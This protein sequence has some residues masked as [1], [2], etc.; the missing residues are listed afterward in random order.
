MSVVLDI[1][2]LPHDLLYHMQL[3]PPVSPL[4]IVVRRKVP[5]RMYHNAVYYQHDGRSPA[6]VISPLNTSL[7]FYT[8]VVYVS[9][10]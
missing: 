4:P 1:P 9:P 10:F 6:T 2:G 8:S 3:S 5:S 7:V